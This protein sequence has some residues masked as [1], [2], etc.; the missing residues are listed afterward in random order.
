M[1]LSN[2]YLSGYCDGDRLSNQEVLEARQAFKQAADNLAELGP[3]FLVTF[4]E[5]NNCYWWLH[6]IAI[7]RGLYA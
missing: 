4:K 3:A 6:D 1:K 2:V 7:A 5:L